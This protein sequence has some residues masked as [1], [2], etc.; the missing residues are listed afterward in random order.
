[1]GLAELAR[2]LW[3]D[4]TMLC[5]VLAGRRWPAAELLRDFKRSR[6]RAYYDNYHLAHSQRPI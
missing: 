1:M 4:K 6:H 2:M 3:V 5:H